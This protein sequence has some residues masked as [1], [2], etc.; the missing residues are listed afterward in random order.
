MKQSKL[1][2]ILQYTVSGIAIGAIVSTLS[3][4]GS[5]GLTDI[6]KQVLVWIIASALIGLISIIYENENL[7]DLTATLI[8]AP[9]TLLIALTAGWILGYGEGSLTVLLMHMVP[10]IIIIYSIIH[11]VLFLIR[12]IIARSLNTRL[13]K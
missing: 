1:Q 11:L 5:F 8:H 6:L 10:G 3:L 4:I 12:R 7:T 2:M 13:N 9:L